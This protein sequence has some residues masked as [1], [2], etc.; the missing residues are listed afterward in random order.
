M[1]DIRDHS[2]CNAMQSNVHFKLVTFEGIK[3]NKYIYGQVQTIY[4]IG[5]LERESRGEWKSRRR[6]WYDEKKVHDLVFP[7]FEI[8]L[9]WLH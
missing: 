3:K 4:I 5:R 9:F 2:Q 8:A 1:K 7:H 6:K